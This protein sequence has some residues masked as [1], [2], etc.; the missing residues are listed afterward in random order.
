MTLIEL[1][2][3]SLPAVLSTGISK[4]GF[5]GAF[6]GIAVP[7][8]ALVMP[9]T[10]AAAIMLP[11]L[12]MADVTGLRRFCGKWDLQN[13][14]IMLPG[15]LLGVLLGTLSFGL[16]S[17][18]LIGLVIGSITIVFFLLNVLNASAA[19]PAAKPR[20]AKGT[21]LSAIAGFTSFVAHAGGPPIMMYLQRIWH[22][23]G[24]APRF[25]RRCVAS[26]PTVR[27]VQFVADDTIEKADHALVTRHAQAEHA[28][29]RSIDPPG[30]Q[31]QRL[32]L[33]PGNRRLAPL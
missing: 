26:R 28:T 2:L 3:L 23:Q 12:C 20:W 32:Q 4:G 29:V 5:G 15:A 16:L 9:P 27:A 13:L 7:L 31:Y 11:I 10:Q 22:C 33:P 30:P 1:F 17:E 19:L 25:K 14:K 24:R 6:G 8:M 21:L 18:R